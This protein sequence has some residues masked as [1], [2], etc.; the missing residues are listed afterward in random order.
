[1]KGMAAER[2]K[3]QRRLDSFFR[4]LFFEENGKPKSANLLYSF[5]LAILFILIY[6]AGYLLLLDPLERAFS[7]APVAVRNLAEYLVP[8][9]AGSAIC[10]L[11]TLLPG[12]KKGLVAG[13]YVWMGGLLVA[14]MLFELLL[15]D[16]SD[17]GTEYSLF[18][19]I[20]NLPGIASV[21]TGGV[22]A[23]LLYRREQKRRTAQETVRERP[24]WYGS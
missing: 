6:G 13:A 2:S 8:A 11:F 23:L 5:I 15:I 7:G 10:L 18:M 9:L 17:A 20:V 21:L 22:P 1:M 16:W 4:G 12:E 19:A 14:M 3:F 24:S